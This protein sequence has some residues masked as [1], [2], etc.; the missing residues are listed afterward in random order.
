MKARSLTELSSHLLPR[1]P[2][3]FAIDV[4][5]TLLTSDH[6]ITALTRDAIARTCAAG[7]E[8]VLASSR[9]PGALART[10]RQLDLVEPVV[11][12]ASGAQSP[13]S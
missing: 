9:P 1:T 5:G 4:D 10:L 12:I 6:R 7:A 3:L 8:V 13:G 11:F 2:R